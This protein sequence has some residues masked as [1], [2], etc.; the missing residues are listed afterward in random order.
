MTIEFEIIPE[1]MVPANDLKQWPGNARRQ[2]I[3][4]LAKGIRKYGFYS[5]LVVQHKTGRIIIG[6]HRWLA[7]K[8][9]GMTEFPVKYVDIDDVT[10]SKLNAY[11]NKI[12]DDGDYNWDDLIVQL[13]ALAKTPE[14]L[15]DSGYSTD[16]LATLILKH[17]EQMPPLPEDDTPKL[18]D[19]KQDF[20]VECPACGEVFKPSGKAHA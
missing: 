5:A 1:I 18:G 12:T 8:L 6:N 14:G 2:D 15:E 11:D 4:K 10:A 3:E 9:C 19:A 20:E 17:A 13:E 16:E 7:G